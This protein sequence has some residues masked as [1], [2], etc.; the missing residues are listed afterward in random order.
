MTDTRRPA[1]VT[2]E[3]HQR[4][5]AELEPLG[6]VA[7]RK[8]LVRRRGPTAHRIEFT[9]SHRNAPGDV[10]C[11]IALVAKDARIARIEPA[12]QAGG[13]LGG[14]AFFDE[15]PRNVADP[16]Q[17][18]ELVGRVRRRLALFNLLD[19]AP[20]IQA[21]VSRRYVPGLVAPGGVVP[22]LLARLGPDA[23]AGYAGALLQGRPELW[24]GFLGAGRPRGRTNAFPDQGTELALALTKYGV[25]FTAEPPADAVASSNLAAAHLRGFFGLMLRAWGEVDAAGNL[26]RIS[27]ERVKAT[28]ARQKQ[29]GTP[30]VDDVAHAGL[31]LQELMRDPLPLRKAPAPRLF[32]YHVLHAPFAP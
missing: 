28:R 9:S 22:Y 24:P 17:A 4:L 12:W 25:E 15:P 11:W 31:V 14:P 13:E 18:D 2:T 21:A 19:D 26:R 29:L 7:R 16:T 6:F 1:Q 3:F 5:A 27:D 20:A 32:Q 30:V 10:T 23:V 8:A